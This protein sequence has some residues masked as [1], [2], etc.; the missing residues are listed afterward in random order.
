[1]SNVKLLGDCAAPIILL[2]PIK[3]LHWSAHTRNKTAV[4]PKSGG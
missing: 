4:K 3:S 1:M 2:L